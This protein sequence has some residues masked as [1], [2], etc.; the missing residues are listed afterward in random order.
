MAICQYFF[1][2]FVCVFY[3]LLPALFGS[4]LFMLFYFFNWHIFFCS[5]Y[6]NSRNRQ[7]RNH[8][9]QTDTYIPMY[10]EIIASVTDE[11]QTCRNGIN[12]GKRSISG[13]KHSTVTI[14]KSKDCSDHLSVWYAGGEC[15]HRH[16]RN[17]QKQTVQNHLDKCLQYGCRRNSRKS[18]HQISNYRECRTYQSKKQ[19]KQCTSEKS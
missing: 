9:K 17:I 18:H 5:K 15:N 7:C 10:S 11:T 6:K 4:R 8:A 2:I 1:W 13:G 3:I 16:D 14:N 12:I 19:R